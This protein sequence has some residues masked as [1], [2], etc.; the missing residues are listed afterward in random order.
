MFGLRLA[1]QGDGW[2]LALRGAAGCDSLGT[3]SQLSPPK[4]N[5]TE[6]VL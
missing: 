2:P 5:M 6:K 1:E 3:W 4:P